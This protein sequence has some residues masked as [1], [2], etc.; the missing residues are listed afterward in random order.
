MRTQ[1]FSR[2]LA[3]QQRPDRIAMTLK[4]KAGYLPN[5]SFCLDSR[6][7][8]VAQVLL[9]ERAGGAENEGAVQLPRDRVEV[10]RRERRCPTAEFGV[11]RD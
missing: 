2:R 8:A 10:C 1:W 7:G 3:H 11:R 6:T 9:R 5:P 4:S